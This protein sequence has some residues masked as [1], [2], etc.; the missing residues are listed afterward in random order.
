MTAVLTELFGGLGQ[1]GIYFL[2]ALGLTLTFGTARLI[3]VAHGSFYMYGAFIAAT[4]VGSFAAQALSFWI[5]IVAVPILVGV[6]GALL[7]AT[8]VR[9]LYDKEHL[10]QLLATLGA[11]YVLADIALWIWGA[12][13]RSVSPPGALSHHVSIAGARVPTYNIFLIGVGALVG[14]V[15]WYFLAR[16]TTGWKVRAAVQDPNLLDSLGIN[17]RRLNLGVFSAG[18]YLGGLAGVVVAPLISVAPGIDISILVDAFIVAIIGGLGSV[19]GA[20]VGAILI[21]LFETAST[22]WAPALSSIVI[23]LAMIATLL[24]KPSGLF[25]AKA[26]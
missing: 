16:T 8:V 14:V 1:A 13:G 9:W 5:A 18:A 11:S 10:T 6:L 25:G 21:G 19:G 3:N 20:A 23:Y 7:E 12:N 2:V 4:V 15:L 26:R 24:I 17:V 22:L